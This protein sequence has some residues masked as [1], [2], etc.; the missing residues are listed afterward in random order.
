[1]F[2]CVIWSYGPSYCSRN[3][4]IY[5]DRQSKYSHVDFFMPVQGVHH[6]KWS[7]LF[8]SKIRNNIVGMNGHIRR[9]SSF[10]VATESTTRSVS[11]FLTKTFFWTWWAVCA[12]W[13]IIYDHYQIIDCCSGEDISVVFTNYHQP[14]VKRFA[15]TSLMYGFVPIVWK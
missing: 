6:W 13:I 9:S 1:M 11:T 15:I 14:A 2:N 12:T 4:C 8:G 5:V 7:W 10:T 3:I